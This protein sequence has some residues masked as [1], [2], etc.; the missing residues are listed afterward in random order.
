MMAS[1]LG[2]QVN[3]IVNKE[4]IRPD[5]NR[6]IIGSNE[7]IK[8]ETGWTNEIPLEKSIKDILSELQNEIK[9]GKTIPASKN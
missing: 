7:K 3:P 8:T 9:H 5:D 4:L 2:I 1:N 6:I